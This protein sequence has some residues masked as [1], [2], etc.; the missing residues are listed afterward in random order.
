MAG[1]DQTVCALRF[2]YGVTLRHR[3]IPERILYARKP[4]ELPVV[5]SADELVRFLEARP[6]LKA[7][8]ALTTAY[9][10]GLRDSEAVNL[11]VGEIDSRRMV[12]RVEHGESLPRRRPGTAT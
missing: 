2:V 4:R 5:L 6:S 8:A 3:E 1:V 11:R 9:A 7:R 10:M 12:I